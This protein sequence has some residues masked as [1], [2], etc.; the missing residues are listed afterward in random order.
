MLLISLHNDRD[1]TRIDNANVAPSFL[2]NLT[3]M[4][5]NADHETTPNYMDNKNVY[6]IRLYHLYEA[7][8]MHPVQYIYIYIYIC[9]VIIVFT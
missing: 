9:L 4:P 8:M 5:Y 7:S 3:S 1:T 6:I 2:T